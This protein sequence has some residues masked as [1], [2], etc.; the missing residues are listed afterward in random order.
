MLRQVGL[1]AC[2]FLRDFFCK[3]LLCQPIPRQRFQT[4]PTLVLENLKKACAWQ[5]S[6]AAQRDRDLLQ[7]LVE[8]TEDETKLAQLLET[9]TELVRADPEAF[10]I[11]GGCG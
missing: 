3:M 10:E 9:H 8:R 11:S 1:H 7:K 2:A 4:M 5:V 6:N